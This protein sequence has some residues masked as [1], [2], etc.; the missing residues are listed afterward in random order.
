LNNTS[1]VQKG[2]LI[3]YCRLE[4]EVEGNFGTKEIIDDTVEDLGE[5]EREVEGMVIRRYS[6]ALRKLN[7]TAVHDCSFIGSSR[8]L[9]IYG[10]RLGSLKA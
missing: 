6:Q 3:T 7:M 5:I 9:K 8:A 2:F 1:I 10:G 4:S